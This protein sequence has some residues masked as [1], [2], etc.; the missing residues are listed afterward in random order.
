LYSICLRIQGRKQGQDRPYE[1][2]D[3]ETHR[4]R[5]TLQVTAM[6]AMEFLLALLG[7]GQ[8]ALCVWSTNICRGAKAF[9]EACC[10]SEPTQQTATAVSSYL[11]SL[12]YKP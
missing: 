8:F 1:L 4:L 12:H 5:C 11:Q 7:V 3:R 9:C 10:G 6:Y 2:I